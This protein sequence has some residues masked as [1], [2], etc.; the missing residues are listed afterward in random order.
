MSTLFS[1]RRFLQAT[2]LTLAGGALAACVAPTAAPSEGAAAPAAATI[3]LGYF[4]PDRELENKE[5]EYRITHFND[6]MAADGK[7]YRVTNVVG[8]ATDNDI[9][10]KLTLDAAA[11][12][13]PDIFRSRPELNA[14]FIAANYLADLTSYLT[15]WDGWD[16]IA[17]S[18]RGPAAFDGKYYGIPG[19]STFTFFRRKDVF[20]AN[21][22][23]MGQPNTWDDFYA[24][25]DAAAQNTDAIPCGLPAATPWGG[26]TWGE[27]FEMVWLSF[28]GTI[29]DSTDNKWVVSSPNLL[30]AFK[31]YETL[32]TNDW[33]TVDMLLS[34][35][36]WE[37][38]KYQG[39]PEGEVLLVTGGDWQWTFDWGPDGAT[40]IEGLFDK[41]DRWQWPSESGNPFTY[42]DV[43]TG[44]VV[45]ANSKSVEGSAEF[46]TYSDEPDVL[47]ETL[48]IYIGGPSNRMDLAEKCPAYK[49]VVNGKYAEA[50]QFFNSGRTYKFDQVGANKISDG[51]GRATEDIIT[52]AKTAEQ[53]M[54]D[55]AT[56]MIEALG[57][58]GAKRA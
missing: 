39:F 7:P 48:D 46:L 52:G 32:A 57:E 35:N 40:P 5:K 29:Y 28:D 26:G 21:G 11:G 12:T 2:G 31:V 23:T 20:E 41:V 18:L 37:P 34:P 56:A 49:D 47:C 30:N 10:T 51:V 45:A 44:D 53:A 33:L 43:S 6:K 13:L 19:A 36:P 8:P 3:E 16:Q 17:E 4:T 22:L 24:A 50:T 38:I 42:L 14:D 27:G 55:F 54:E 25:C 58:E 9:K 15:A 1:R